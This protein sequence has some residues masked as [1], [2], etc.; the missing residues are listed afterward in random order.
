VDMVLRLMNESGSSRRRISRSSPS[1]PLHII[2]I[3]ERGALPRMSS[4]ASPEYSPS[5][6][7]RYIA[8]QAP[9]RQRCATGAS[10]S[11]AINSTHQTEQ[12]D[13]RTGIRLF[14]YSSPIL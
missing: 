11:H 13:P 4:G 5:P 12:P 2:Y 7:S 10:R 8:G 9:G 6:A 1:S 14:D 3:W